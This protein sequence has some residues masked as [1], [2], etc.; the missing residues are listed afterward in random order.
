[1]QQRTL[2][3]VLALISS[4]GI[5]GSPAYAQ[6]PRDLVQ[7]VVD[8]ERA[9]NQKD[10]SQWIYLEE[11]HKPKENV[12]QWVATTPKG[13]VRRVLQSNGQA[14]PEDKQ[15]QLIEQFLHDSHAQNKEVEENRH[16]GQQVDDFLKLLPTAFV[17][18]QTAATDSTTS[19]H[20]EPDPKFHPPTREARVFSSM[21]GDLVADNKHHRIQRMSGRLVHDVNFG[22]GLLGK[23][24][25][26]STFALAQEP[27]GDSF[28]ELT[29]IHVHLTGNALL[30]KSVSLEQD[31][32]RAHFK[33]ESETVTLE[34]AA[35]E[36]QQQ[37]EVSK[38]EQEAQPPHDSSN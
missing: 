37:P 22:G 31:Q 6:T 34:Q 23:L 18:T 30:F 27:V 13:G 35:K 17:W 5:A 12:L 26:G 21:A 33:P 25:Q 24:R 7:Q 28:W 15:R 3:S 4:P 19:F 9:E 1:M 29:A 16:D 2:L 14:V 32:Q 20:F 11:S 36:V 38:F 10:H 8:A